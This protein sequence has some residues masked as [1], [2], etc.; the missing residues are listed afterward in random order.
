MIFLYLNFVEI[1]RV[2]MCV[3]VCMCV[4]VSVC[5]CV[6]IHACAC[7]G[8]VDTPL[9]WVC[10]YYIP[11]WSIFRENFSQLLTIDLCIVYHL[12]KQTQ[13]YSKY[14]GII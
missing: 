13:C 8:A 7:S 11:I 5:V 12:Q 4:S 1:N 10:K 14:K 9:K 3:C 6:C 2:C